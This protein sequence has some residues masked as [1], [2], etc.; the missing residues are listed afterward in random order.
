MAHL[1]ITAVTLRGEPRLEHIT[2]I[3]GTFGTKTREQGVYEIER[4]INSYFTLGA[5]MYAETPIEVVKPN[6]LAVMALLG[7]TG[8]AYLRSKPNLTATDN[9]L[10]LPRRPASLHNLL[11][12]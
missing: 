12:A 9:L 5:F 10:S 2:H 4:G 1:Q 3:H 11:M 8:H 6:L 7:T